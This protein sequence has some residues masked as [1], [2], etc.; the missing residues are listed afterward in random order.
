MRYK[1]S[2]EKEPE[3][4]SHPAL[5]SARE[6]FQHYVG[7]LVYGANDGII[8]TFAVVA[9][10]TGAGLPARVVII[11]GIS[12]LLADGF[13]MGASNYL[14]IRSKSAA[15]RDVGK[16]ISE[17]FALRHGFTTFAAF[18]AAGCVPL[19]AYLAPGVEQNHFALTTMLAGL[20]LFSIGSSRSLVTAGSWWRNG[21]EMLAVGTAAGA[22]SFFVGAF[23]SRWTGQ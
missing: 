2:M 22:V 5:G 17:P 3:A 4:S 9:G 8:T 16:I 20:A 21:L 7:D 18:I 10:V 6:V 19:A 12:N 14:A 11:L 13:S 1:F 23:V 15:E